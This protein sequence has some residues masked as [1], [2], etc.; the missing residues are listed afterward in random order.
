MTQPGI[1]PCFLATALVWCILCIQA[2]PG[3][4]AAVGDGLLLKQILTVPGRI[5]QSEADTDQALIRRLKAARTATRPI[6]FYDHLNSTTGILNPKKLSGADAVSMADRMLKT[7][8]RLRTNPPFMLE[9]P[10]DWGADH[11]S[12]DRNFSFRINAL[13]PVNALLR[14]FHLTGDSAYMRVSKEILL[15]WIDYNITRD[16]TNPFKWYDMSAGLRATLLA[17]VLDQE[18]R[19]RGTDDSETARLIQAA[20][21]HAGFLANEQKLAFGNHGYFQLCGLAALCKALPELR[22]IRRYREFVNKKMFQQVRQQFSNEGMYLEHSAGYHFYAINS[23][24][25]MMETGWFDCAPEITGILKAARENSVWLFHPSGD[26]VLYGDTQKV[27]AHDVGYVHEYLEYAGTQGIKGAKPPTDMKI[28]PESG[29][30]VFRSPWESRPFSDQSFLFFSAAYHSTAHKHADDFTFEWSELGMPVIVNSGIFTYNYDAFRKYAMS[31]RAHNCIEI[32][33]SSYPV[34]NKYAYGSALKH[35]GQQNGVRYAEA[36]VFHRTFATNHKRILLLQH[37]KWLCVIDILSSDEHHTFTQWF[38]FNETL[39]VTDRGSF[40]VLS[41]DSS[42]AKIFV[43]DL[44]PS[45]AGSLLTKGNKQGRLQGWHSP[46]FHKYV[47]NYALGLT[48]NGATGFFCTLFIL[49]ESALQQPPAQGTYDTTENTIALSWAS[50]KGSLINRLVYKTG[51]AGPHIDFRQTTV[52]KQA[53]PH[54]Q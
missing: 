40:F 17:Y 32:D 43:Y 15:D 3:A 44:S 31:T 12:R 11:F 37:K 23:L 19:S 54:R 27:P 45:T 25:R 4:E 35:W 46:R 9:P 49:H 18:L 52:T 24:E 21:I 39:S 10:I 7:G 51:G 28:F 47:P 6:A 2:Q 50:P 33:N 34:S 53:L 36:E 48:Q 38:H 1:L 26:I 5:G 29:Y 20:R 30:A 8:Y 42:S 14:A 13:Y 16:L 41:P 22:D